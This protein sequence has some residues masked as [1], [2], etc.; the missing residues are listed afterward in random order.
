VV[1]QT[2]LGAFHIDLLLS[3]EFRADSIKNR[4]TGRKILGEL[5]FVD[6]AEILAL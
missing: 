2:V 4:G 3:R 5:G 6:P 1:F